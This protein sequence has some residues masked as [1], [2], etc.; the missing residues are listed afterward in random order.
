M[1]ISDIDTL[2]QH[3]RKIFPNIEES[4]K[5]CSYP[6]CRGYIYL[7]EDEVDGILEQ[8]I[9]VVCLNNKVFLL[10]NFDVDVNGQL[11]LGQISPRCHLRCADGTCSI[12]NEKKPLVCLMYPIL[13]DKHENGKHYWSFHKKCQY[14][15][16]VLEAG[17]K[18]LVVEEFMKLIDSISPSLYL[19]IVTA[20]HNIS[21]ISEAYYTD[22]DIE[23][24]KEVNS[25]VQV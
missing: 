9:E 1:Y 23:T 21:D 3:L 25:D 18:D 24:I 8:D 10:N 12:H 17:T 5:R 7:L 6:D 11:N 16:D 2:S 4:C 14:Y 19:K 15:Q 13:P 22:F 20:Y